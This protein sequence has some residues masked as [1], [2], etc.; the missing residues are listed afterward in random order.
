M[1]ES[2]EHFAWLILFVPLIAAGIITDTEAVT[3]REYDRKVMDIL[4]VDDFAP[5]ELGTQAEPESVPQQTPIRSSVH[6]A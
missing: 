4:N 6:V 5:H 3:L 1:F 2:S